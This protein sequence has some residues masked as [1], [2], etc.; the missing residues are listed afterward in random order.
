VSGLVLSE[1]D[2]LI[3]HGHGDEDVSALARLAKGT[4]A[5]P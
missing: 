1:E 5:Q 4:R 2:D 3:D